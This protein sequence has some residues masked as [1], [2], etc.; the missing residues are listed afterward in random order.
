MDNKNRKELQQLI[1]E[2]TT[3]LKGKKLYVVC[4]TKSHELKYENFNT[5]DIR[6]EYLS[7][8]EFEQVDNMLNKCIPVEKYFFDETDFISFICNNS[9]DLKNMIVYNSAQSGTGIGRK[10]LIPAFCALKGITITGSNSYSVALCRHKYHVI[11]LLEIHGLC[12]PKTYLYDHG[13]VLDKPQLGDIYILKPIYESSSIGIDTNSVIC[14]DKTTVKLV[15][16][17]QKEMKQPIIVQQFINGYEAEIPCIISKNHK[18]IL[19]PVGIALNL[20]D[21][22]MGGNIL[23]YHKV[24]YDEYKFFNMRDTLVDIKKMV[25]DAEL[26]VKILGLSGLCRVDFRIDKSGCCYVTDVSTNPHF[27]H[28]SSVN[29]AFEQLSLSPEAIM[30]TILSTALI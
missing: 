7:D 26:V 16:A 23:D 18:L 19:D 21:K 28:H 29:Y 14:F 9:I 17:K 22:L 8:C 3:L 11:K 24:Y 6:T 25:S 2:G 30:K 27:V 12:V 13:W 1:L 4:N 20:S 15:E 10:S 5:F